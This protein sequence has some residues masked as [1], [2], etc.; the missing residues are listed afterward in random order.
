MKY[1]VDICIKKWYW[2]IPVE[3]DRK[4]EAEQKALQLV[5]DGEIT[6][7]YKSTDIEAKEQK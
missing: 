3:A 5:K 4:E 7:D 2:D 1:K 6:V